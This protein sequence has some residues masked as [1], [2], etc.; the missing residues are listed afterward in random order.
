MH[1]AVMSR[2]YNNFGSVERDRLEANVNSINFPEFQRYADDAA[3][4]EEKTG[5]H[6]IR[7]KD[8][9]L[10][11]AE[12]ERDSGDTAAERLLKEM[13][14]NSGKEKGIRKKKEKADAV[15][16]FIGVTRLYADLYVARDLSNRVT[17]RKECGTRFSPE[18]WLG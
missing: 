7:F 5:E 12:H 18:G 11:L 8:D 1:L 2:L 4:Y 13:E 6:E 17:A 15:R 10:Q 9:L 16:L 14:G 3:V